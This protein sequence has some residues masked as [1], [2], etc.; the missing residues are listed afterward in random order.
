MLR[1]ILGW[2]LLAGLIIGIPMSTMATSM[3]IGLPSM[4]VGYLIMLV[5][6]STVFL[7]IKRHRDIDLGGV[8]RFWPAFAIGLAISF[9]ASVVYVLAWEL[10]LAVTQ[11]DF[12]GQY[13]TVLIEQQ[14]AQGMSGEALVKYAAG[15][16]RFKADYANPA[17]ASLGAEFCGTSIT[18]RASASP[19]TAEVLAENPHFVFADAQR[20]GYGVVECTPLHMATRLRVVDE[21]TRRDTQVETLASFVVEAGRA[22]VERG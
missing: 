16:E 19:R 14:K 18:S 11:M 8:I 9:V 17:S 13:A 15:L 12:A 20:R 10:T 2:G 22:V 6:L 5:A 7:A 3:T 4:V 1:K 21:V